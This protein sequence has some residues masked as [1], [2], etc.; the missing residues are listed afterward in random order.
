LSPGICGEG[1]HAAAAKVTGGYWH[2]RKRQKPAAQALDP[3]FQDRL[4][5][6]LAELVG[7][8]LF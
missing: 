6:R 1:P 4:G 3:E 8:S 2:H 7:I 5:A